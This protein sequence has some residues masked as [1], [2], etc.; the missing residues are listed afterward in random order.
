M[1]PVGASVFAEKFRPNGSSAGVASLI[2]GRRE[3]ASPKEP[4]LDPAMGYG[5]AF[6]LE[7]KA[8]RCRELGIT[9]QNADTPTLKVRAEART[10]R[11]IK[12]PQR[13]SMPYAIAIGR[14]ANHEALLSIWRYKVCHIPLL[15]LTA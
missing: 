10:K 7:A 2:G 8:S 3:R 9:R 5:R 11:G 1:C 12:G 6:G 4:D 14:V 13:G 15:E